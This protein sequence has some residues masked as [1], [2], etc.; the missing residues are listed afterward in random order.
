MNRIRTSRRLGPGDLKLGGQEVRVH[1]HLT[2]K[3]WS[4]SDPATRRVTGYTP[5]LTLWSPRAHISEAGRQRA[6]REGRRNV[7]CWVGGVTGQSALHRIRDES[8]AEF[9]T[10]SYNPF[11]APHFCWTEGGEQA[12]VFYNA[13]ILY[14]APTGKVHVIRVGQSWKVAV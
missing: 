7:H 2:A 9:P 11:R 10:I 4:V 5:H 13:R 8:L 1:W 3:L 14:F 6:I 12:H